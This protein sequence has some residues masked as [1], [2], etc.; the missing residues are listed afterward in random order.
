MRLLGTASS[1]SMRSAGVRFEAGDILYG[2][3]RPYLNKVLHA[4]FSGMCSAEFI[5]LPGTA[6]VDA[7]FL[8]YR[9][10]A[11]DFVAFAS[12]Q[13]E[14]DRP[15]VDFGQLAPFEILLPPLDEQHR[16]VAA[17]EELLS[18]LAAAAAG[19][20]R[21]LGRV[22]AYLD[23]CF[24]SA[25][26]G[27]LLTDRPLIGDL[28]WQPL[29][30][31]IDEISQGWSPK[32]HPEPPSD[33]HQWAVIKTTA[34]QPARFSSA[35]CKALPDAFTPRPELEVRKGDLLVTRKGPRSRAGVA[36]AVRSTRERVMICDTVYRLRLNPYFARPHFMAIV[37]SSPT[38]S[39]AIDA[40]KAGISESG[41]SLTHDRLG[42]VRVPLPS[43]EIQDQIELEIDRRVETA[44]RVMQDL[45]LQ[46]VRAA[47]LREAIL[48]E[49]FTGRLLGQSPN[50][51]R[52]VASLARSAKPAAQSGA[53][54][55]LK[56]GRLTSSKPRGRHG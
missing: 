54:R 20:E 39:A 15:R 52:A 22:S 47:R 30:H 16:I 42:A 27:N 13:N 28:N 2:R 55:S 37:M 36:A 11:S 49:A 8:A 3:L 26:M 25:A 14:G 1:H 9:L 51:T 29:S 21:A 24:E 38:V 6:K 18:D 40:A 46:L 17:L 43:L 48:K 19:L 34:I 12:R 44:D 56:H 23:S 5:V 45:R 10:N 7:K 4:P 53:V 33:D 35:E 32:C 41:V 31:I 50:G